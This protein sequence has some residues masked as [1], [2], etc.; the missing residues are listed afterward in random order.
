MRSRKPT[1]VNKSWARCSALGR[2]A[3]SSGSSTFSKAVKFASSWND[4]N[5]KPIFAR[6][7]KA[8]ASSLSV[9]MRCPSISTLPEVGR[10]KPA[11]KASSVDLPL[12]EGPT[13][14]TESP[15]AISSDT[16]SSTVSGSPPEV[17]R[18]TRSCA[19]MRGAFGC[20][21]AGLYAGAACSE[22]RRAL[23]S[24]T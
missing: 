11:N 12:P 19:A 13:M 1:A 24:C 2:R 3:S 8:K 14:A 4:W 9:S 15:A 21:G 22:S 20:M 18:F 16:P 17:R 7:S 10:S 23:E 6:R 5:T